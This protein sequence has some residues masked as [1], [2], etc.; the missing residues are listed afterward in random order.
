[1]AEPPAGQQR[2]PSSAGMCFLGEHDGV[3][4]YVIPSAGPRWRGSIEKKPPMLRER[5]PETYFSGLGRVSSRS[6]KGAFL[7][8]GTTRN[9]LFPTSVTARKADFST[10]LEMTIPL[11][12]NSLPSKPSLAHGVPV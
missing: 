1:M 8:G 6:R 5:P 10:S 12:L 2:E 4:E 3:P 11:T 7:G 9:L